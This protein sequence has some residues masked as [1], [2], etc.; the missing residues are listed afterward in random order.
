MGKSEAL[1][2]LM[3]HLIRA[4]FEEL[5]VG[6]LLHGDDMVGVKCFSSLQII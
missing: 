5:C 1:F 2:R 3:V 4:I 6:G